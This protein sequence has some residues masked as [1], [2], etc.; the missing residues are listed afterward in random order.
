V[1]VRHHA[2]GRSSGPGSLELQG[3]RS[4]TPGA[5]FTQ[6][7]DLAGHTARIPPGGNVTIGP[8]PVLLESA[9][10]TGAGLA[11]D[12][13]PKSPEDLKTVMGNDRKLPAGNA[14]QAIPADPRK[15]VPYGRAPDFANVSYGPHERNVFDFWQARS[16]RPAPLAI[17][18]HPGGFSIGDKTLPSAFLEACLKNGISVATANYR[19]SFQAHYPAQLEDSARVLQFLRLHAKE[20]H[21]DPKRVTVQGGSS[22]G[23]ISMWLGF[24]S[25]MVD[26]KSDDPVKALSGGFQ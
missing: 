23:A 19:Y 21:I 5:R 16:D 7:R 26:P 13:Q 11:Q 1:D 22:G 17:Y 10:S 2:A 25:D 9:D 20:Y 6:Y 12:H 24:K 4:Y 18:Y 8:K 3:V 15:P 14:K